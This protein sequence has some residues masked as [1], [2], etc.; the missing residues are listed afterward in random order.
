MDGPP[1]SFRHALQGGGRPQVL[2]MGNG[3][4]RACGGDDWNQ[5]LNRI[6]VW[7]TGWG[8]KQTGE[9]KEARDRAADALP[10]SLLYEL[11]AIS[12]H[13]SAPFAP[14]ELNAEEQRF[15]PA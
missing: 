2:L 12:P 7:Y 13:L 6:D 15:W 9:Q 4:E 14:E 3:L 5:L 1:T 11:L 8:G 10:F